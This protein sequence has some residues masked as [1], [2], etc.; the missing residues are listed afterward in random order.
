[1]GTGSSSTT[2]VAAKPHSPIRYLGVW[3]SAKSDKKCKE[4]IATNE[5]RSLIAIIKTKKIT[6]DQALYINNK[7]LISRLEYRLYTMFFDSATTR[8][9][10]SPITKVFKQ[11]M[12]LPCTAKVNMI[13]HPGIVGLITLGQNQIVHH[14]TEFTIRINDNN[15]ASR[16]SLIRLRHFQQKH[17]LI[18][19]IWQTQFN[20]LSCLQYLH[21]LNT[22]TLFHMKSYDVNINYNGDPTAWNIYHTGTSITELML[23]QLDNTAQA[24]N[25]C[26]SFWQSV[27]PIYCLEQCTSTGD[28]PEF[29]PWI[30]IKKHMYARTLKGRPPRWIRW[31]TMDAELGTLLQDLNQHSRLTSISSDRRVKEWISVTRAQNVHWIGRIKSKSKATMIASHWSQTDSTSPFEFTECQGCHLSNQRPDNN[32]KCLVKL[33][34]NQIAKLDPNSFHVQ[35]NNQKLMM[36]SQ[37]F[38]CHNIENMIIDGL[39]I[40]PLEISLINSIVDSSSIGLELI[41]A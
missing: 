7:V 41:H 40:D 11:L 10:Y 14:F 19:S 30:I 13:T 15:L 33:R 17:R 9:L 20:I 34:H 25:I 5:I 16:T 12:Q 38:S 22:Y 2:V 27:L 26:K 8:K 32:N 35:H 37:Q 36:D 21:N 24:M 18:Q 28:I 3:L 29:L 23:N 39:S 1:M 4:F 31:L 6:I